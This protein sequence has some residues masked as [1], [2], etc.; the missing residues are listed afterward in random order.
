LLLAELLAGINHKTEAQREY[1]ALAK[2]KP[3]NVGVT[4]ALGFASLAVKNYE[5]ARVSFEKAFAAGDSNP[6]MCLQLALME[7]RAHQPKEKIFAALNKALEVKPDYAEALVELGLMHMALREFPA[8]LSAFLRIKQVSPERATPIY[9]SIAYCYLQMGELEKAKADAVAARQWTFDSRQRAAQDQL[10]AMIDG[11]AKSAFA[12]KPGEQTVRTL[13]LL[14]SIQCEGD[15]HRLVMSD[16]GGELVLDMPEAAA[17][18]FAHSG[19]EKN[20]TLTCGPQTPQELIVD[21]APA[22]AAKS[23]GSGVVRRVQY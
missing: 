11:R 21:Y 22:S 7:G 17:I 20:L 8:A 19:T 23:T 18:E 12:P 6:Q 3:D 5:E 16:S 10:I 1:E 4:E 13:G 14:K 15:S 2:L 9:S